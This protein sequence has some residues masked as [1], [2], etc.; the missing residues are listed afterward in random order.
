VPSGCSCPARVGCGQI[1]AA[2]LTLTHPVD[3]DAIDEQPVDLVFI[4]LVPHE[5]N[6][7]HLEVLAALSRLF[8]NED[9]RAALRAAETDED[10]YE[11]LTGLLAA[12][13]A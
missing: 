2:C 12:Q 5:E 1:H 7:A 10:L 4:L 11:T 8:G 3:Y 13:A 9:N 6:A